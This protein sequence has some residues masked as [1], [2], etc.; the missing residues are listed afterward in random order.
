MRS[1]L[2][3]WLLPCE[4]LYLHIHVFTAS[5][6]EV[7]TTARKV[8]LRACDN[9]V[10]QTKASRLLSLIISPLKTS[11]SQHSPKN[12]TSRMEAGRRPALSIFPDVKSH[13]SVWSIET[14]ARTPQEGQAPAGI[15]GGAR[16]R[17]YL[18]S[19]RSRAAKRSKY[20]Q[21]AG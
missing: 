13:A 3:S 15:G 20:S 7:D 11:S 14:L 19:D 10:I 1:T 8:R 21:K 18:W 16:R 17:T 6:K 9:T 2:A 12:Q 5:Q 4:A